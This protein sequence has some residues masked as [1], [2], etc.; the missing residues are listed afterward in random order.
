M[1]MLVLKVQTLLTL[2]RG[3][4]VANYSPDFDVKNNKNVEN[5]QTNLAVHVR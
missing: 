4:C 2:N 3:M 1:V 5:T